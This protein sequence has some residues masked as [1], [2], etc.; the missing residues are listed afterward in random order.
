MKKEHSMP[1]PVNKCMS[2]LFTNDKIC[3]NLYITNHKK[4][5]Q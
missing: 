5:V 1:T 4:Q 3:Q 2:L